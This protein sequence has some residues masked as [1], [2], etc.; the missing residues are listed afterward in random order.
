MIGGRFLALLTR[1]PACFSYKMIL[2]VCPGPLPLYWIDWLSYFIFWKMLCPC[3]AVKFLPA[4]VYRSIIV[5]TL[6]VIITVNYVSPSLAFRQWARASAISIRVNLTPVVYPQ[7]AG[8]NVIVSGRG[9]VQNLSWW[10]PCSCPKQ[11]VSQERYT[12]SREQCS[13]LTWETTLPAFQWSSKEKEKKRTEILILLVE[14]WNP[15]GTMTSTTER[16]PLVSVENA[17]PVLTVIPISSTT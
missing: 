11:T 4:T 7:P 15:C 13:R 1:L 10:A 17:C 3:Y 12:V 2:Y 8:E 16:N 14:R 6:S 9:T 5:H